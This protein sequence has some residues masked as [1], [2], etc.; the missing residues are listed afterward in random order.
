[1]SGKL[2]RRNMRQFRVRHY[3]SA[4]SSSSRRRPGPITTGCGLVK[5]GRS[6]LAPSATDRFRG[7][8]PG[9]PCAIAH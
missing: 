3:V 6:G 4:I 7:M 5:I 9:P 8:G 2:N 1:M